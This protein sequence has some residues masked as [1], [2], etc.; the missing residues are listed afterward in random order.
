MPK[1][2]YKVSTDP[3]KGREYTNKHGT[4]LTVWRLGLEE[5]RS[6]APDGLFELHKKKAP[7]Q[8]GEKIEV[9]RTQEGE[10]NG[11]KF[12]RLFLADTYQPSDGGGGGRDAEG[13]G[14]TW[15]SKPYNSSAEHPRNEARVIHTASLG[16]VPAYIDQLL[17]MSLVQQ[18]QTEDE[19]WALVGRVAGRLTKSYKKVLE[20]TEPP[21]EQSSLPVE[22]V[23]TDREGLEPQPALAGAGD[24]DIPF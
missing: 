6:A 12:T 3:V 5:A 19:Y 23:P 4:D 16:N 10:F 24:A 7:P 8:R 21:P 22:E 14:L 1:G 2:E 20:R 11:E 18:P 15:Q 13:P 9:D 17:T